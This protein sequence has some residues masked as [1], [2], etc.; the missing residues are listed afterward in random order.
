VVFPPL[1]PEKWIFLEIALDRF[2]CQGYLTH[3]HQPEF[4]NRNQKNFGPL[5]CTAKKNTGAKMR[6]TKESSVE[7]DSKRTCRLDGNRTGSIGGNLG[8][9]PSGLC[10]AGMVGRR[11][12]GTSEPRGG[13]ATAKRGFA[14]PCAGGHGQ[15]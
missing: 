3:P 15:K 13:S 6:F 4:Q 1:F 10:I 2:A 5:R 11:S 14:P 9:R 12:R 8:G 7:N